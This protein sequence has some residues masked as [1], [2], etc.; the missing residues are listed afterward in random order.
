[1]T[2]LFP[3]D[4]TALSC[5]DENKMLDDAAPPL[6]GLTE[7]VA[8]ALLAADGPNQLPRVASAQTLPNR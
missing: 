4:R 2:L 1:V 3:V 5:G 8:A 6:T 7:A